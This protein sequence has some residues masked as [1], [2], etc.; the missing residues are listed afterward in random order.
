MFCQQLFSFL[1]MEEWNPSHK[2]SLDRSPV[3]HT[4]IVSPLSQSVTPQPATPFKQEGTLSRAR[5][6]GRGG[7]E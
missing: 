1:N 4:K 7:L 6:L 3:T 5:P 2:Y